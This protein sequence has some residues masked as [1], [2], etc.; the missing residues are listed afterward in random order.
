VE[1]ATPPDRCGGGSSQVF[2]LLAGG[3][4]VR[5]VAEEDVKLAFGVSSAGF[6]DES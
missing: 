4:Q 5:V 2:N 1:K 6:R 3:K